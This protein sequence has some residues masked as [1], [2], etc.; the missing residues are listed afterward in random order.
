MRY[1]RLDSYDE[2]TIVA[3]PPEMVAEA[4]APLVK[5]GFRHIVCSLRAPWDLE[6]IRRLP[7]VRERLQEAGS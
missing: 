3:G 1:Q 6:T 4:L 7:E 2:S 5:A